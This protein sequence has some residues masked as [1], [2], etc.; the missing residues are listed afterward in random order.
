[1]THYTC[2]TCG[3]QFA[4]TAEPPA[5]CPICDDER[6]YVGW[7]GQ[8]W[9]TLERLRL[10]RRN[11]FKE[12]EPGLIGIGTEP[13]FAIGQ[14]AL[15]VQAPGGNVLW[16]CVSLMDQATVEAVQALGGIT[17]IAISHPHFYSAMVEWSRAF[18]APIYLHESNR[19]W[20]MRPD[21][22]IVF[23]EGETYALNTGLTLIRCGGHF[24]GSTVLH[25]AAGAEGRGCLLTGDT[26]YVVS[27]R[28]YVSFMRSFP[29]LIPL[30]AIAVQ[31]IVNAVEPFAYDRVYSAWPERVL[32]AEAK[33]AVHRSA[34][35]YLC[36][37]AET[38]DR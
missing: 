36:A 25:W 9:T 17:A 10:D 4:E 16:D 14:R 27:D 21:P 24:A 19:P 22:A 7:Q 37:L 26:L 38:S 12:E 32:R 3:A 13:G 34:E 8:H 35:R 2:V 5:H 20:V 29:N 11:V 23:W 28:R 18:K 15:L 30:P 1:M 6:Q 33:M 31:R